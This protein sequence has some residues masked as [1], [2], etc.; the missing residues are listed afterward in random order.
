MQDFR[1]LIIWEKSHQLTLMIYKLTETFPKEETFGLKSQIRRSIASIPTNISEGCV[2]SS[3]A[4]FS[5]F[6]FISLGSASETEY[7]ILLCKDLNYISLQEYI[8]LTDKIQEIKKLISS[9]I[10]KM[11][12]K[13]YKL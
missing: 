6:L 1:N 7:L 13:P 10:I 8:I 12:K 5:R 9:L 3:D 11:K 4:D 2:K